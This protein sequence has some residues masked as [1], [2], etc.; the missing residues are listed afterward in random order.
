LDSLSDGIGGGLTFETIVVDNGSADNSSVALRSRPGVLLLENQTNLGY[1]IAVNQAYRRSRA[2]LILLLNSDVELLPGSVRAL[3]DLLARRPG[4]AAAAPLYRYP[5]GSPQ[6][7]HFR[8]PSFLVTL[9]NTSAP[10]RLLPGVRR[11]LREF[12][13]LDDDFSS[14]RPVDQPSTSCLL[15]RRSCLGFDAVFDERYPIFFNDVDLARGLA[16]AGHERWV[17]PEAVVVHEDHASTRKLGGARKRQYLA[18][19][20]RM[21]Q[22]TEPRRNVL[23]YKGLVLGQGLVLIGLRRRGALSWDD[24]RAAASGDPGLLP[25]RPVVDS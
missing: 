7:F 1:A 25:S 3:V 21:L 9:A 13:M 20:V 4:A 15:I 22:D 23:L 2:P 12:Q 18:S 5:D 24:L 17:T 11:R 10:F 19:V 16:A 6:P 14:A 8:F